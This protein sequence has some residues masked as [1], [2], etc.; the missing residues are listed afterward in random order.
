MTTTAATV[1]ES[2]GP[3]VEHLTWDD[4]P[5]QARQS[6]QH[7]VLDFLGVA[8]AGSRHEL[9]GKVL[10]YLG[11][12]RLLGD[13]SSGLI[14]RAERASPEGAAL[15]NAVVGHVLD[16]D[17]SSDTLGG[18]PTVVVLPP[19]LAL[20]GTR[21]VG[22]REL[23][24]AYAAGVEVAAHLANQVNIAH[25]ERGW[26]PTATL[27]VFG[28]AAASAKLLGLDAD[29][30]AAALSIAAAFPSGLRAHF[31]T[32]MKSVQ[33]GAAA[34]DGLAAAL[35]A[36]AGVRGDPAAFEADQGFGVAYNGEDGF[37]RAAFDSSASRTWDLVDPGLVVKQYPCC[38]SAH[39]AVDAARD[40]LAEVP[41]D[42]DIETIRVRLHPRR[43]RHTDN[44]APATPLEAK[45][46]VQYLVATALHTGSVTLGDFT[47]EAL[48]RPEVGA[49]L[50][51]TRAEPFPPEE[52][53]PDHYAG[54]VVL[55]LA[56]G[57][58]HRR[59]VEKA[60]GRGTK[61]ALSDEEIT[62]KFRACVAPVLGGAAADT[63]VEAVAT[64]P[65]SADVGEVI[66]LV[67]TAPDPNS[68]VDSP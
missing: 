42:T 23:L 35:L 67:T 14:G 41:G 27:G 44:P 54:E 56:D 2:V 68:P 26:H 51:R 63:I 46:S 55:E 62:A 10:G 1:F 31:G 12:A 22:G 29:G 39:P 65:S 45:F 58:T 50:A 8:V 13:D 48:V 49:L 16:F 4:V 47:P 52:Y 11:T 21:Q 7:A 28:G 25:Y 15:F 37:R 30:V 19:L 5:D 40:L 53:G 61:L 6:T 24:T 20:A 33:V 3:W 43:L 59:R 38:A 66:D 34:R 17:D 57:S 18:H 9:A 60:R 36:A 64:L 32:H